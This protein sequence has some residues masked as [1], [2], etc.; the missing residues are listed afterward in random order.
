MAMGDTLTSKGVITSDQLNKALEEQKK[1]G[2]KLGDILV[3]LGFTTHDKI[4]S[5]LK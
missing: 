3:K 2:E 5:A 1:T 4:D